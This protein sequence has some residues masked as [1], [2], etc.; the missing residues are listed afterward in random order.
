MNDSGNN[1]NGTQ[2]SKL[3]T[4]SIELLQAGMELDGDIYDADCKLRLAKKGTVLNE[5]NLESLL[6]LNE[7]RRTIYVTTDTLLAMQRARVPYE[8]VSR[9]E[10]EENTGYVVVK[11][12]T[13]D[14]LSEITVTKAAP[15]KTLY[16]VSEDLS[17][18][19]ET[20]P[21]ASIL[22]LINALAPVDEYL[23]RHCV[24]VGML[25]GLIGRWLGLSNDRVD[26]LILTGLL[27]D[28]GKALVPPVV[29]NAPRALTTIEAEVMKMHAVYSHQLLGDFPESVRIAASSH[30]E[31][32]N[33]KGYPNGKAAS[34]ILLDAKVTAISDIY[35]AMISRRA[36]KEPRSPFFTMSLMMQ[37]RGTELDP[38]LVDLFI[39]KMPDELIG[40]PVTMSNGQIAVVK[41]VDIEDIQ[42]PIVE[43]EGR[44]FKANQDLCCV[45][46]YCTE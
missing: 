33:G 10:H 28:C 24:N 25:N 23:E 14:I 29:L 3:V 4:A 38:E 42:F 34:D 18:R 6:N 11:T 20:I 19:L 40:K 17:K 15:S 32:L 31:K 43:I 44:S 5:H 30:H 37:L 7:G 26:E 36:Y 46:M 13:S 12:N 1:S 45:S 39:T 41:S 21:T 16:A 8:A 2:D 22:Q 9:V 35:D 27:H